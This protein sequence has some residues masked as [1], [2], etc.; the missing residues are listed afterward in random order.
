MGYISSFLL[1]YLLTHLQTKTD[2]RLHGQTENT[3]RLA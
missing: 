3:S 1:T 2:R